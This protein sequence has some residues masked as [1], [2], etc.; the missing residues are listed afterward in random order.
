MERVYNCRPSCEDDRPQ[1]D[2]EDISN[3]QNDWLT[4]SDVLEGTLPVTEFPEVKINV[5]HPDATL[6]DCYMDGGARGL[7]SQRFVDAV[8]HTAFCGLKL[9]PATLNGMTYYFLRCENPIDCFD[10]ANASFKTFRSDPE[11]IKEIM[12]YAFHEDS[13]P[14]DACFVLPEVPDLFVTEPVVNRLRAARLRG[15]RTEQLP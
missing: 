3:E 10:R 11:S 1:I 6:W 4:V 13:L 8:G 14:K 5:E 9:L 15:V 12:H 2:F 7:F